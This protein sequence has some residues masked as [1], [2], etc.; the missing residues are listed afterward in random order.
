MVIMLSVLLQDNVPDLE[1]P[2]GKFEPSHSST[3]NRD[4]LHSPQA[5]DN[6][7]C[8]LSISKTA[9]TE[10][11]ISRSVPMVPFTLPSLKTETLSNDEAPTQPYVAIKDEMVSLEAVE[12]DILEEANTRPGKRRREETP[13]NLLLNENGWL[14]GGMQ[15]RRTEDVGK[16]VTNVKRNTDNS[17]VMLGGRA[18][19]RERLSS[20]GNSHVTRAGEE[21]GIVKQEPEALFVLPTPSGRRNR[22]VG[23]VQF[24]INSLT[25]TMNYFNTVF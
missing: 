17:D 7:Q 2:S 25:A 6:N 10:S 11:V 5:L 9:I 16:R 18:L 21:T 20:D 3:Q 4:V 15:K 12:E 13:S 24:S 8:D 1:L 22:G 14:S 19:K 23:Q